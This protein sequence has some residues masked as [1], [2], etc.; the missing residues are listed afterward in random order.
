MAH[1]K[2]EKNSSQNRS[3]THRFRTHTNKIK[4]PWYD[5]FLQK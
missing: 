2:E 5:C 1:Q 4:I 3:I